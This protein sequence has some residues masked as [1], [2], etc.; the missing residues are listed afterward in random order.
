MDV[1][2]K[3]YHRPLNRHSRYRSRSRSQSST[4]RLYSYRHSKSR[5]RQILLMLPIAFTTTF[6]K[7]HKSPFRSHSRSFYWRQKSFSNHIFRSRSQSFS[8]SKRFHHLFH[9][10]SRSRSRFYKQY[11]RSPRRHS[12]IAR[13]RSPHK[14]SSRSPRPSKSPI[15]LKSQ[16]KVYRSPS[17]HKD[18]VRRCYTCG[19]TDHLAASCPKKH[20]YQPKKLHSMDTDEDKNTL[21][22]QMS[23]M[24]NQDRH[25]RSD[26]PK[27]RWICCHNPFAKTVTVWN[28]HK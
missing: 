24:S 21:T 9:S 8:N 18:Q 25:A 13:S 2:Q 4:R 10:K 19:S 23:K 26:F 3:S 11:S 7:H 17:P 12:H 20:S 5:F 22:S 15:R 27:R 6:H 28:V 1:D 14:F 16:A